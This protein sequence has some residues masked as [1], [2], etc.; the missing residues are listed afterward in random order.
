MGYSIR[1]NQSVFNRNDI[2]HRD[3]SASK[4]QFSSTDILATIIGSFTFLLFLLIRLFQ[5]LIKKDYGT[6]CTYFSENVFRDNI[7][8]TYMPY[9]TYI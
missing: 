6:P 9:M 3:N 5:K 4:A 1:R 2:V 7:Y 8:L